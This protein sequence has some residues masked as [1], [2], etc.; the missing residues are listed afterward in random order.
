MIPD[1]QAAATT[2]T[3]RFENGG[4]TAAVMPVS[5]KPLRMH[6]SNT[7]GAELA[8]SLAEGFLRTLGSTDVDRNKDKDGHAWIV[9]GHVPGNANAVEIDIDAAGSTTA[10]DDLAKGDCDVGMASRWA[11]ADEV[12]RISDAGHGDIRSPSSEVVIGLDGVA[13]IVNSSNQL[14]SIGTDDLAK[15]FDG[16][17]TTWPATSGTEGAIHVYARDDRSGTYDTFKNLVLGDRKLV[18]TA[19]RFSDSDELAAAV[20]ADPLGIGF[21]GMSHVG[22][23]SAVAVS[24]GGAGA[25]LPS[26]FS[27]GTEDYPITR[28]LYLYAPPNATHPLANRL[29]SFALSAEGQTLVAAAGF[30]NLASVAAADTGRAPGARPSTWARRAARDASL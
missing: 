2:P 3:V 11:T 18:G 17:T 1:A 20:A 27:V 12:T 6:G 28:R 8:P 15:M 25:L 24:E 9:T 19:K 26:R 21:T 5:T 10:F 4:E 30:V 22:K 14:R 7:I 23:A 16:D 29:V 13:V